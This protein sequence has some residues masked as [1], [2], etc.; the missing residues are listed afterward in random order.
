MNRG[1]SKPIVDQV[2][3]FDDLPKAFARLKDGPMGTSWVEK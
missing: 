2:F 3:A 1:N